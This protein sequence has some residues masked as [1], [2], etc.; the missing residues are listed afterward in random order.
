MG[1]RS[2]AAWALGSA[3]VASAVHAQDTHIDIHCGSLLE[4][5]SGKILKDQHILIRNTRIAGVGPA[6]QA[7]AGAARIDLS[8][9]T[10]LPGLFDSHAHLRSD[11]ASFLERL[12]RSNSAAGFVQLRQAQR[13]LHD[14]FTTLRTVGEL[15]LDNGSYVDLRNAINRGEFEGPR[16]YGAPYAW[17]PVGGAAD[18]NDWPRDNASTVTGTTVVAGVDHIREAVRESIKGGADWIK[19]FASGAVMSERD[20]VTVAGFT[21]EEIDAFADETHRYKKKITAHVHGNAAALMVARAGFDSIEHGTM[22]QDDAIELIARKRIW[23]VPTIW[24]V[25]E[26]ARR[27]TG[28]ANPQKPTASNCQ[29]ILEIKAVRDAAFRKAHQRGVRMAFGTDAIWGVQDNP[30]EFAALTGLGVKPLEAIRMATINS[31]QMMGLDESLGTLAAGK[32]ADV[33]AVPGDPLQDITLMERVNFVMKDGKV[34]RNDAGAIG[35]AP[36]R[37]ASDGTAR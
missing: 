25:N 22:M 36:A 16:L 24:I 21:Q 5:E 30:K 31:A 34:I 2:M 28:E 1:V 12:Q 17:S 37:S 7:P 10:C 8:A 27:C 23:F 4:V 6:V 3:M 18:V 20:D 29:K 26:V 11:G 32:L 19:V 33:V 9:A 15:P 35:R 14:G 13:A